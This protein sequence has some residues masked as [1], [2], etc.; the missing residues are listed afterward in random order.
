[1]VRSCPKCKQAWQL[2]DCDGH[3]VAGEQGDSG[4]EETRRHV[5]RLLRPEAGRSRAAASGGRKLVGALHCGEREL[6]EEYLLLGDARTGVAE[7][8]HHSQ[9][10]YPPSYGGS[11]KEYRLSGELASAPFPFCVVPSTL[12]VNFESCELTRYLTP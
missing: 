1:M 10:S 7:S 4:S 2:R 5:K 11:C 9:H 8:S 12:S 6:S 3:R